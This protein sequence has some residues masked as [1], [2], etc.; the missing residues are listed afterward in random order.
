MT[1]HVDVLQLSR[2]EVER[3]KRLCYSKG[4]LV[5]FDVKVVFSTKPLERISYRSEGAHSK[6]CNAGPPGAL[7]QAHRRLISGRRVSVDTG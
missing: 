3:S 6:A 7:V 1:S 2:R 5:T 4:D